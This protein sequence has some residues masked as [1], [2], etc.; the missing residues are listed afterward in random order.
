M[1]RFTEVVQHGDTF[2]AVS[3]PR[4]RKSITA[5]RFSKVI[6]CNHWA[7]DFQAWCEI[8]R[9]KVP[10]FEDNK[11]TIA[12]KAIESKLIEYAK[13]SVSPYIRD[14]EQYFQCNDAKREMNFEFF[15]HPLFGG[16]WDA[17][18]FDR[19]DVVF[20]DPVLPIAVI[21]CKTTSR[22]QDWEMGIPDNY[23]AQG[24]LYAQ[25]LDVEDVYFPV[26]FLEPDD[27]DDP[28]SFECT[29]DN[30]RIYHIKRDEPIGRF[31]NILEAMEFAMQWN[32]AHVEQ[33]VS[34]VFNEKKDE[35]YLRLLRQCEI[36]ELP[37]DTDDAN[38]LPS[39]L[40]QLDEIDTMIEALEV[41]HGIVDLKKQRKEVNAYVQAL[42]K[43]V[44]CGLDGKDS[45]DTGRYVFTVTNGK[46][47]DY[48]KLEEDGVFDKYVTYTPTIR[49]KRK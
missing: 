14:P 10:P 18:A 16:M 3:V 2:S 29:E 13:G 32:E 33:N 24:L 1:A 49:T 23:K 31:E 5:G 30:T 20:T 41:E 36:A 22:P 12:G 8:M 19:P 44:L 21:E 15:D 4:N 40:E 6:G 37:V 11:Y 38:E 7:T 45:V 43:P 27:Y 25:L 17:L 39:Y 46:K 26:A 34:P 28:E 48:G 47:V 9:C 42:V 35:E